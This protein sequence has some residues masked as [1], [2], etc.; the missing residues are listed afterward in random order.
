MNSLNECAFSLIEFLVYLVILFLFIILCMRFAVITSGQLA[1]QGS[2][3]QRI[4]QVYSVQMRMTR[5]LECAPA[6]YDQWVFSS[7]NHILWRDKDHDCGWCIEGETLLRKQG[8]FNKEQG[9]WR[10]KNT[11]LGATG[12]T[13][14]QFL[15]SWMMGVDGKNHVK[16]ITIHLETKMPSGYLW[17]LHWSVVPQNRML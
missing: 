8:I 17:I 9:I 1:T 7:N 2:Y 13:K 12:I 5:D 10:S 16:T 11:S 15:I 3:V 6:Q 14:A 4:I